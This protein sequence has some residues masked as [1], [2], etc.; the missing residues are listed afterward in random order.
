VVFH[1]LRGPSE[2]SVLCC[3]SCWPDVK[4]GCATWSS[5]VVRCLTMN[6]CVGLWTEDGQCAYAANYIMDSWG[7]GKDL[8][9]IS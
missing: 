2:S 8:R 6:D 5:S 3:A 4:A 1:I 7:T 9:P